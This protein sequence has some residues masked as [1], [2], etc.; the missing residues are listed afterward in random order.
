MALVL[1]GS[2]IAAC[3]PPLDFEQ[4]KSAVPE[5]AFLNTDFRLD[6]IGEILTDVPTPFTALVGYAVTFIMAELEESSWFGTAHN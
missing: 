2:V 6:R 3:E 1:I 4:G 5:T